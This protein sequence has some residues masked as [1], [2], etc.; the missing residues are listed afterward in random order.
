MNFDGYCSQEF[1]NSYTQT[2]SGNIIFVTLAVFIQ[3]TDNSSGH[4]EVPHV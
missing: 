2:Y 3:E 1:S 4:T